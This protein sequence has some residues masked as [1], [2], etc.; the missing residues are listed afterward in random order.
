MNYLK[1]IIFILVCGSAYN[2]VA[3]DAS[4]SYSWRDRAKNTALHKTNEHLGGIALT[5]AAVSAYIASDTVRSTV[6]SAIQKTKD[7][8]IS[9]SSSTAQQAKNEP[10]SLMLKTVGVG[11]IVYK[12][13]THDT[14]HSIA[15]K[16][17]D[18]A[19]DTAN[20]TKRG[21]ITGYNAISDTVQ[22]HPIKSK[23]VGVVACT[24]TLAWLGKK[25]YDRYHTPKE[26][27]LNKTDITI[28]IIEAE[29]LALDGSVKLAKE[30]EQEMQIIQE[31]YN[32]FMQNLTSEQISYLINK[33]IEEPT[34]ENILNDTDFVKT[35]S[36][37]QKQNLENMRDLTKIIFDVN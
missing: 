18:A 34:L 15:Q 3:G 36:H 35:L 31:A 16:A 30:P 24:A 12:I 29:E 4:H 1:T 7:R 10:V 14:I 32:Q 20:I 13:A 22:E 21:I 8:I 33:N 28:S 11:A 5:A 23:A 17:V 27:L 9:I 6:D 19:N 26:A 2:L 37:D 25:A